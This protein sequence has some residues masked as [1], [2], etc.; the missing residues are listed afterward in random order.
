MTLP[1]SI[2]LVASIRTMYVHHFIYLYTGTKGVA[3]QLKKVAV[4][5]ARSEGVTWFHQLSD[6]RKM[7]E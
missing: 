6:K 4:G 1:L 2:P 5:A 3:K 7:L